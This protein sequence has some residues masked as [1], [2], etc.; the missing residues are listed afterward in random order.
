MSLI[1]VG[2]PWLTVR[3]ARLDYRGMHRRGFRPPLPQDRSRVFVADSLTLRFVS[4]VDL[5]RVHLGPAWRGDG[6]QWEV[7][8]AVARRDEVTI[9]GVAEARGEL[10]LTAIH[11]SSAWPLGLLTVE[12]RMPFDLTVTVH[13]RYVLPERRERAGLRTGMEESQRRGGGLEFLGVREYRPGDSRRQ[14][15]WVTTA[16][17]GELA[18]V[19]RAE[20]SE[21]PALYQ[22]DL[23]PDAHPDAVELAVSLTAS[24]CAAAVAALRPFRLD[25]RG[26]RSGVGY[27]GEALRL[28]A[29][30]QPPAEPPG[31]SRAGFEA[32]HVI[33][34]ARGIALVTP[35]GERLFPPSATLEDVAR[36]SASIA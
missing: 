23:R 20:E 3:R 19:E 8:P 25:L 15:H 24:L 36:A 9:D 32:A 10:K 2:A 31:P 5:A 7:A 1:G 26:G 29:M 16:R 12:R 17:R 13:P 11:L 4:N 35:L 28:L 21:Q 27:W 34:T 18:V 6:H 14:I 33:A 22:L 30:A